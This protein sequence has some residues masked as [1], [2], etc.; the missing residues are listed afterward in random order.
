MQRIM[1]LDFGY[2]FFCWSWVILSQ[3]FDDTLV[4]NLSFWLIILAIIKNGDFG[5][6]VLSHL[7]KIQETDVTSNGS[8]QLFSRAYRRIGTLRVIN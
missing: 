6:Q 2:K 1:V 8:R 5:H 3:N 7:M 4:K